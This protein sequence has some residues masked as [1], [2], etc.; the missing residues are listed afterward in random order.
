MDFYSIIISILRRR[1]PGKWVTIGQR[2]EDGS[3]MPTSSPM[4]DGGINP[5]ISDCPVV[6]LTYPACTPK[7]PPPTPPILISLSYLSHP[8]S[9]RPLPPFTQ[10]RIIV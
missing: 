8:S 6:Q 2:V 3:K 4:S 5:R 10:P 7:S 9:R 1:P